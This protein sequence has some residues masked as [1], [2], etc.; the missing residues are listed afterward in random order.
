MGIKITFEKSSETATLLG[1]NGFFGNAISAQ[2][3]R[4]GWKITSSAPLEISAV[5]E[6]KICDFIINCVGTTDADPDKSYLVNSLFPKN[7]AKFAQVTN[8]R[9]IHFGSSAEYAP[10]TSLLTESFPTKLSDPYS[11][12]KLAGTEFVRENTT[13]G[14]SIVLRPFGVVQRNPN[15]T[16]SNS[17]NLNKLISL[18]RTGR[19]V[20]VKNLLAVRDLISIEDVAFCISRLM[21]VEG[22][23]PM[24]ANL[25]SGVGH[26]VVNIIR[27]VNPSAEIIGETSILGDT[28]IGSPRVIEKLIA[29]KFPT[30]IS[31]IIN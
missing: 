1:A 10:S 20:S 5:E 13:P 15:M 27:A 2:L 19:L 8:A 18:A 12:S 9:L 23:W 14:R 7:L 6:L 21:E 28:Y 24:I 26:T 31:K 29:Y 11:K 25:A 22:E 4:D 17:S 30:D 3:V 16:L